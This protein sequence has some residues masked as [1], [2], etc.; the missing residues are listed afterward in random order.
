MTVKTFI[1]LQNNL[2]IF[3]SFELSNY[4]RILKKVSHFY[5]N[6]IN[7]TV[8]KIDNNTKYFW[9][10]NNHFKMISEGLCSKVQL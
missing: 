4:Q 3:F 1:M 10:S 5:K 7:T 6:I 9:A 8:F 2:I